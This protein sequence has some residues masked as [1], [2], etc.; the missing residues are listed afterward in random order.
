MA[1]L[2]ISS[3]G[4][5]LFGWINGNIQALGRIR[6]VN[7]QSEATLNVL[8]FMHGVNPMLSPEGNADL[9]SHRI[10]WQAQPATD[11]LDRPETLYQFAL[12]NTRID[13]EAV[14]GQGAF[15]LTL[16]QAGFKQVRT[17]PDGG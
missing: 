10:R 4:T 17:L 6:E 11:V 2:L 9:G 14:S 8:E 7:A 15:A 5:A 1:L 3:V 16:L 12:Y 13:V